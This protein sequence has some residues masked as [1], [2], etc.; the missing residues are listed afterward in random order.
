QYFYGQG[1]SIEQLVL[2]LHN[3]NILADLG[4]W[5]L[6]AVAIIIIIIALSG[7]IIWSRRGG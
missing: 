5:L 2:D 6:D 1:V 3:G 7:M 4:R